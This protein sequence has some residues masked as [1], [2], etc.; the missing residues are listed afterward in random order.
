MDFAD[1]VSP[2]DMTDW[3]EALQQSISPNEAKEFDKAEK[4]S[5]Q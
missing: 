2:D 1:N 3:V 4:K 5:L